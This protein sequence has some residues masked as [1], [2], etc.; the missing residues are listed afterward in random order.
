MSNNSEGAKGCGAIVLLSIWIGVGGTI[1]LSWTWYIV[2]SLVVLFVGYKV[3]ARL[4]SKKNAETPEVV[5]GI[6]V[7]LILLLIIVL[8]S[9]GC[10]GCGESSNCGR[11][12]VIHAAR[13]V[14]RGKLKHP[15][16]AE[17]SV[18]AGQSDELE[19]VGN[20]KWVVHG[21]VVS[22]NSFGMEVANFYSLEVSCDPS[23]GETR[24][25]DV[26]MSEN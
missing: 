8:I 5:S 14:I 19:D 20:N 21:K 15:E 13:Q 6:G 1:S 24:V 23:S 18:M 3:W 2:L 4:A 22:K 16:T 11:I 26:S 7:G 9:R 25:Y 10:G 17:F 12:D